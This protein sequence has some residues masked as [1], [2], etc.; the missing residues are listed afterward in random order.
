MLRNILRFAAIMIACFGLSHQASA[1]VVETKWG[2]SS[3]M[4]Y[5]SGFMHMLMKHSDGGVS[6]FNMDLVRNDAPGAGMSDKGVSSDIIWGEHCARKILFLD[7]NR[8]RKAFLFILIKKYSTS[9]GKHPVRYSVNGNDEVVWD[10]YGVR[11]AGTA[12]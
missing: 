8:A 7:D 3:E 1:S 12:R 6:L 10:V 9:P 2:G 4:V 11:L 5:D